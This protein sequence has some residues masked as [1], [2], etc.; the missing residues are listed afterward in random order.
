MRLIRVNANGKYHKCR[1]DPVIRQYHC[2]CGL[3]VWTVDRPEH[4]IITAEQFQG[5]RFLFYKKRGRHGLR[6]ILDKSKICLNC[7]RENR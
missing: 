3:T 1:K 4:K 6:R 7:F 5:D 2:E